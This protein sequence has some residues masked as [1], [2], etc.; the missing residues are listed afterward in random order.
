MIGLLKNEL[1][2]ID[3]RLRAAKQFDAVYANLRKLA[4]HVCIRFQE[5]DRSGRQY[6][7]SYALLVDAATKLTGKVRLGWGFGGCA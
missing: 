2:R 6:L 3:L 5:R 7:E 1:V 4:A